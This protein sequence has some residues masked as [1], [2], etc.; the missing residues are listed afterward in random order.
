MNTNLN[1]VQL[2]KGCT[3]N[4]Q[5]V[6]RPKKVYEPNYICYYSDKIITNKYYTKFGL[7]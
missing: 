4:K 2:N 3:T 1:E 5:I 7:I 6:Y